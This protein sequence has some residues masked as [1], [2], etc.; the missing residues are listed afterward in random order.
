MYKV[1]A[2][3][4]LCLGVLISAQHY[5][6]PSAVTDRVSASIVRITG[7]VDVHTLFDLMQPSEQADHK[8]SVDYVC[9]GFV[10]APHRVLT[11]AH[12]MGDPDLLI[13]GQQ[14]TMVRADKYYDLALYDVLTVKPPLQFRDTP[15]ARYEDLQGMGYAF[16]W[17]RLTPLPLKVLF[18]DASQVPGCPPGLLVTPEFI[19]GQSGGPIVD[20]WGQ[21]VG[22]IQRGNDG[23]GYGVGTV[24]I[25]AFLLGT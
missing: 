14:A 24:I 25:R 12:C 18:V 1:L 23:T 19:G 11:A 10:I 17:T 20:R 13:D 22:V 9:S 4:V 15:P 8:R 2:V 3:I 16:S 21:V 6:D 7:Q 5:K